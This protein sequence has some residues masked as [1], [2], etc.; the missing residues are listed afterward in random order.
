MIAGALLCPELIRRVRIARFSGIGLNAS[1]NGE[2]VGRIRR[3]LLHLLRSLF[4]GRHV[5]KVADVKR[6]AA[7]VPIDNPKQ[8]PEH[9]IHVEKPSLSVSNELAR[10]LWLTFQFLE[11]LLDFIE[12]SATFM[13]QNKGAANARPDLP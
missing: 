10:P 6:I 12:G 9:W 4:T 8:E 11:F 13:A 5:G 1:E 3:A 2:A 7:A